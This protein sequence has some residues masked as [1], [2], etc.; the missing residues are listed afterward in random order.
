MAS[1][2]TFC[3]EIHRATPAYIEEILRWHLLRRDVLGHDFV[4]QLR[5]TQ[6]AP[7]C[8]HRDGIS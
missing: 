1:E 8:G 2:L 4:R 5:E 6:L 7:L 3:A